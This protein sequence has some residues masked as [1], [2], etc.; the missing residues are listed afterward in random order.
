MNKTAARNLGQNTRARACVCVR[1]HTHK[2]AL[3][4]KKMVLQTQQPLLLLII[5]QFLIYLER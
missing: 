4:I 2:L 5:D 1:K 3:S